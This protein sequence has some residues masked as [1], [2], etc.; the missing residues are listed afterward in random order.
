MIDDTTLILGPGAG[1]LRRELGPAVWSALEAIAAASVRDGEDDVARVGVRG[2]AE[3]MGVAKNT[4]A[5]AVCALLEHG[6]IRRS[7]RRTASGRFERGLYVLALPHGTLVVVR[8]D[9]EVDTL[10]ARS[11]GTTA[12]STARRTRRT[13]SVE[14]LA[15]LPR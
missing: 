7:Q 3:Q 14:Q 1:R 8:S 2:L 10:A 4:A 5:R 12:I 13:S 11:V 15:L 6:L 9:G